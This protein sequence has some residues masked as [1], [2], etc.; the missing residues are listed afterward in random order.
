MNPSDDAAAFKEVINAARF[1]NSVDANYFV[2]FFVVRAHSQ[3][4]VSFTLLEF[5]MSDFVG[6]L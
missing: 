2:L 4:I 6:E 3:K 1:S 5:Y